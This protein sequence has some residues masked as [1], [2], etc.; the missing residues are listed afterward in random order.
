MTTIQILF[1]NLSIAAVGAVLCT[2]ATLAVSADAAA[3][4]QA[5]YREDMA[6]CNSG[7]S[8][9]SIATCKLEARNALAEAKRGGLNGASGQYQQNALQR[10]SVFKGDDL[11]DC[12]A[13]TQGSTEGSVG[14]GGVL[15]E[16]VTIVPAK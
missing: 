3:D 12:L 16:G 15:H 8:N 1:R 5:R 14:S 2:S 11:T 4:A 7:Q 10:C 6:A 13:R 9:Q